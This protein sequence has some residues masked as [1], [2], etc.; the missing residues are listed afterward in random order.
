MLGYEEVRIARAKKNRY[1]ADSVLLF[2]RSLMGLQDSVWYA[3][4][5]QRI[6]LGGQLLI[7]IRFAAQD[8]PR[9][10]VELIDYIGEILIDDYQF[11]TV[12]AVNV[13]S[14]DVHAATNAT[15]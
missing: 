3:D 1:E 13:C 11:G 6:E 10:P 7:Q 5:L 14:K 4:L 9:L 12:A 8:I 15:L 2:L